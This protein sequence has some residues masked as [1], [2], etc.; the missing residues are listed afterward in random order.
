MTY[1]NMDA[2][3][4]AAD[5]TGIVPVI[6]VRRN[7]YSMILRALDIEALGVQVSLNLNT[8]THCGC[9]NKQGKP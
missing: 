7:D 4:T 2:L 3:V 5:V 9:F 6:R 1:P 8:R